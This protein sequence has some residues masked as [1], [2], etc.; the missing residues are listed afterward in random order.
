LEQGA[1]SIIL[2]VCKDRL[3]PYGDAEEEGDANL[4][5]EA[6]KAPEELTTG[7]S[8]SGLVFLPGVARRQQ[9][10]SHPAPLLSWPCGVG[11]AV[12]G[13]A[14]LQWLAWIQVALS[15]TLTTDEATSRTWNGPDHRGEC[16]ARLR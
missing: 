12:N 3:G 1:C 8:S 13:G 2:A 6:G 4:G 7:E 15:A 9:L 5:E 14:R 16:Q 11:L 10:V